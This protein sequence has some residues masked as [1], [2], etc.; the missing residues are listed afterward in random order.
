M[1]IKFQV[2]IRIFFFFFQER[3]NVLTK[4][5]NYLN[6]PETTQKLPETIETI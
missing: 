2:R 5:R 3:C 1:T 6:P 4:M